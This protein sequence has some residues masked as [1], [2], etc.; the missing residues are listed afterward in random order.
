MTAAPLLPESVQS[1][2]EALAFWAET[3][4]DAP[5]LMLAGTGV[6]TYGD[7]WRGAQAMACSLAQA[8]VRRENRVVLLVSEGPALALSLLGVMSAAIAI[9]LAADITALELG[10][11]LDELRAVAAVVSPKL[12][13]DARAC[14][15]RQGTA[16]FELHPDDPTKG[17][18]GAIPSLRPAR[19]WIWPDPRDIAA[20]S[21]T[22]GTTGR[23]KRSP[24]AHGAFVESGRR[25]RDRFGLRQDDRALAVAPMSLSLGR[26]AL[27]HSIGAGSSLIFPAAPGPRALWEA[28]ETERP[29]WMHASAGFLELL[30]DWLRLHPRR[31]PTSLRLVRVTAAPI[32]PEVCDELATRLGARILPGYST[33]E[34]GLIATAMPPPE[35]YKPGSTGRPVQEIRIVADDVDVGSGVEGEIWVRGP[36]ILSGY[37]DDPELNAAAFTPDGWLRLGDIGY[38]DEDGFLFLTGRLSELVNRGGAKISPAEVD[39]VLLAHPGVKEGAVFA[40]PDERLGQDLVAAVVAVEGAAPTAREL[41]SWMLDRLALDKA[42]R[43]IWFV[44]ELPRTASGKVRRGELARLWAE[45]PR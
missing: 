30:N 3:T 29:T 34:T 7:L 9:P 19:P 36:H 40:V 25:H 13:R 38:L 12:A 41:R 11:M 33:S 10:A 39:A 42:P 20:V 43:R 2:P 22:S 37:L 32:A 6:I 28:I 18:G 31:P 44:D 27:M 8:G 23:P 35:A 45:A 26:T 24:R 15:E 4:P 21:Q 16:L 17:F 1:V 14:L 5:A